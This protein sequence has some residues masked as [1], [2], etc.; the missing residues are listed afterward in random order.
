MLMKKQLFFVYAVLV[1]LTA[2]VWQPGLANALSDS[3][4]EKVNVTVWPEYGD[5]SVLVVYET[6]LS[7]A[8]NFPREV[9]LSLPDECEVE[10]VSIQRTDG[11]LLPIAWDVHEN[12]EWQQIHFAAVSPVSVLQCRGLGIEAE[13]SSRKFTF[14]WSSDAVVKTLF[15]AVYQPYGAGGLLIEPSL[16]QMDELDD[17]RKVYSQYY[18]QTTLDEGI[19]LDVEYEK[20][21]TNP[22]YPALSVSAVSPLDSGIIGHSASPLNVV[23]W[24]VAVAAM[25]LILVAIYYWWISRRM[26]RKKDHVVRG[27]GIL[28]P[29]KQAVFCHECGSRSKAGDTYCRSCGTEL[30]RF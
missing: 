23:V 29:E 1:L 6:H 3:V 12:G 17:G 7:E 4:F 16:S 15:L 8:L 13:G 10:K 19:V 20:D 18:G 14:K 2:L 9:T 27:V 26:K 30:R 5:P 22:D 28:N 25:V 21:I 24:L 11:E